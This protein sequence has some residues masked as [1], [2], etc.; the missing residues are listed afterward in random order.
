MSRHVANRS[1]FRD[2]QPAVLSD[3][4]LVLPTASLTHLSAVQH[5]NP[6]VVCASVRG[7]CYLAKDFPS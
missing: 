3:N 1:S 2:K 6:G 5:V 4:G 7:R